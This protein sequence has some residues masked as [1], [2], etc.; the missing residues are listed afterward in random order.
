MGKIRQ[1]GVV[2]GGEKTVVAPGE[3]R[4]IDTAK[5]DQP[6]VADVQ[7]GVGVTAKFQR[8]A[9]VAVVDQPVVVQM[10]RLPWMTPFGV[11]LHGETDQIAVEAV[12]TLLD[13]IVLHIGQPPFGQIDLPGAGTGAAGDEIAGEQMG[14]GAAFNTV[15]LIETIADGAV[16]QK[17]LRGATDVDRMHLSIPAQTLEQ[18][19]L[20]AHP[21]PRFLPTTEDAR[22]AIME[23]T[24]SNGQTPPFMAN[25]GAIAV[26]G[27]HAGK[28]NIFNDCIVTLDDPDRFAA[29][30]GAPHVRHLLP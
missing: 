23:I 24:V 7:F 8:G 20:D 14:A 16:E 17:K 6:V 26:R 13:D 19:P 30:N 12:G 29:T 4:F 1:T 2:A 27:L 10:Q 28:F 15:G 3:K 21:I 5:T 18:T 11:G 9:G 22:F 25:A